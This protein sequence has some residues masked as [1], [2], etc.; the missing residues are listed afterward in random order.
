MIRVKREDFD[1]GASSNAWRPEIPGSAALP[2]I[3]LVPRPRRR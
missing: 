1:L 3:G 2:F